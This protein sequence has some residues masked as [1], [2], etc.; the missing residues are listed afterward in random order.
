M[1]ACCIVPRHQKATLV[2][3]LVTEGGLKTRDTPEKDRDRPERIWFSLKGSQVTAF[4]CDC[5]GGQE[6]KGCEE[7]KRGRRAEMGG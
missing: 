7:G 6:K 3:Y 2:P 1:I 5:S 4:T